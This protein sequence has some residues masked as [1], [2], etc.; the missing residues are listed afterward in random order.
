MIDVFVLFGR[1]FA[2]SAVR[3][4]LPVLLLIFL[5]IFCAVG[6]LTATAQPPTFPKPT[7]EVQALLDQ[8]RPL[9]NANKLAEAEPLYQQARDKALALKDKAGEAM[10]MVGYAALLQ[11][12]NQLPESLKLLE[13]ALVLAREIGAKFSEAAA[14]Q[15]LGG[16]FY[17]VGKPLIAAERFEEARKLYRLLGDKNSEVGMSMNLGVIYENT[18]QA[19]KA[20]EIYLQV[21]PIFREIKDKNSEANTLTN[22]GQALRKIGKN[23]EAKTYELQALILYRELGNKFSESNVLAG[24]MAQARIE[25]DLPGS[26]K[27]G[28]EALAAAK[29]ARNLQMESQSLSNL[30]VTLRI[31]GSMTA[32][33]ET[34][35]RALEAAR[36]A[37]DIRG[38]A[39]ILDET[40][41][42]YSRTGEPQKAMELL[43][44]AVSI[45]QATS[46]KFGLLG[47]NINLGYVCSE[48][49]RYD[50]AEVYFRTA[51][52]IATELNAP[53]QRAGALNGLAAVMRSRRNFPL[54]LR[55]YEEA[56]A[57]YRTQ[58]SWGYEGA[59]LGNIGSVYA[60]QKH[61]AESRTAQMQALALY[62]KAGDNNG[63]ATTLYNLGD[64][65]RL[66]HQPLKARESYF[67]EALTTARATGNRQIMANA[68]HG[69]AM[70]AKARKNEAEAVKYSAAGIALREQIRAALGGYTAAKAEFLSA[71]LYAYTAHLGLLMDAG[72]ASE[73]FEFVQKLK[74]RN[75]IDTLASGRVDLSSVLT[76]QEREQEQNLRNQ[77]DALN[78]RMV[79]EGVNNE[80]GG[81]R[82]FAALKVELKT[83]ER[84]LQTL[85]DTLYA[86]HPEL[87]R[88]RVAQTATLA[89]MA[90]LLPA[91]AALL[92]YVALDDKT[93]GLFVMTTQRGKAQVHSVK[94]LAKEMHKQA[95][96]FRLACS[97][98]HQAWKPQARTLYKQLIAPA[99]KYLR[100]KTRLIICPDGALWDV[101]FAALFNGRRTLASRY[102]LSSAYSATGMQAA[103]TLAQTHRNR[104]ESVLVVANPDFGSAQRFNVLNALPGQRPLSEP[105]RPI[106]DPSR[107]LSEPSRTLAVRA[108]A[109]VP[110]R[111]GYIAALAGTQ[112]E[113]DA[114]KA[115]FPSA[116]VLTQNR[117]QEATVKTEAGKFRYLHFATHGFVNDASPM[118]SSVVLAQPQ[119]GSK[120]DGF[121]TAREVYE[122]KLNAEMVTLSA[123]NSGRG[124]TRS[125]EGIVGL[126]WALL[127]AGCPTQVVSQWSVDDAATALLMGKFY[128]N[129]KAG[130][131]KATA[132][133]Q[134]AQALRSM[135]K[136]RHPYY[137][138]AFV[139]MG[140]GK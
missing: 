101:P 136:Y 135:P 6:R 92:E 41:V 127:C 116:E 12:K 104:T 66:T 33:L 99:S 52:S 119:T 137:W 42:V 85:T 1:I 32:A 20:I 139:L 24:L 7:P 90:K 94:I 8:A 114:I 128:A 82:R 65:A 44:Q 140:E 43:Q 124:E 110:K 3:S 21:L 23:A 115:L 46:N 78:E 130:Q 13:Q 14:I 11:R 106:S 112:R 96:M 25:N 17:T 64:I 109:T 80:I 72:R 105:A 29:E 75:L 122:L 111:G 134:A 38:E 70:A 49:R 95:A 67:S 61:Y 34:N 120:D 81:K 117:A 83:A 71:S 118:L 26:L 89:Q 16:Y 77:T 63:I 2:M 74:A 126:T 18:G 68:L 50:Q 129:L 56:L 60:D 48:T 93:L 54:S 57:L 19:P 103:H 131:P 53:G 22:L 87:S 69:L 76:Q 100:G 132:L 138:A 15:G 5:T 88:R 107:P 37:K 10:T 40:A 97:D 102:T 47:A 98:P 35:R 28:E 62:R 4:R 125:G 79:Q 121:L 123:C 51:L 133:R 55:Y 45:Y 91:D 36:T 58:K 108:E 9:R 59:V 39:R 86:R 31:M 27:L 113:A 73:A 30:A 84:K